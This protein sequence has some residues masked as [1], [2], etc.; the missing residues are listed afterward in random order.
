VIM[1]GA[2]MRHKRLGYNLTGRGWYM[3]SSKWKEDNGTYSPYK[4]LTQLRVTLC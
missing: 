2:Q 1:L 3:S 4:T